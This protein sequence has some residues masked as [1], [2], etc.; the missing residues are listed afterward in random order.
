MLIERRTYRTTRNAARGFTLLELAISVAIL[1]ILLSVG[2]VAFNGARRSSSIAQARNAVL[3]YA[4]IARSYA[5]A[6]QIE[7]MFVVN[8]YNGRFEIW[9]LNPPA[10][11]GVWD[12]NSSGSMPG[13]IDGYAFAPVLDSDARLPTDGNGDP[14]VYVNPIDYEERSRTNS[15]QDYDNL[16]W[17]AICF[18]ETGVIVTRS[19]RIATQTDVNLGGAPT[20]VTYPNRISSSFDSSI[21][22]TYAPDMRLLDPALNPGARMMVSM[23]DSLITSTRGFVVSDRKAME[24][25]IG[26][27]FNVL[28]L[29]GNTGD[30]W[31]FQTRYGRKYRK[32]SEEILLDK[33]SAEAMIRGDE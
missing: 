20:G 14:L 1:A 30:D 3:S 11:G 19:R 17:T 22:Q 4:A 2:A 32:F 5:I 18:D 28:R 12:P 24:S 13:E 8:P 33:Y 25:A 23:Y 9:H 29:A 10:D 7:T 26:K 16:I 15:L 21:N 6:N 31:L 27:S